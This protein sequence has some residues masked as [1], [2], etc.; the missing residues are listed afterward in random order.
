MK[1]WEVSLISDVPSYQVVC[2]DF[3]T[4][5]AAK[6]Y[7]KKS[8]GPDSEFYCAVITRPDEQ[9]I[10]TFYWNGER[11]IQWDK[12][13]VLSSRQAREIRDGS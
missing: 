8:L 1:K 5:A 3:R 12:P 9:E 7:M 11:I 13:Y 2:K 4:Q 10:S 6:R